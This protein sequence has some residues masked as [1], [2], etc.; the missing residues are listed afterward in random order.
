M[1]DQITTPHRLG[2]VGDGVHP[3]NPTG[4]SGRTYRRVIEAMGVAKPLSS[5]LVYG[6]RLRIGSTITTHPGYAIVFAG[7]PED[8]GPIGKSGREEPHSQQQ[9]E[10]QFF[11]HA[12][13]Y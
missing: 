2:A 1:W 4:T 6:R 12:G 8:V 11:Y 5:Q 3:G 13:L 10:K 9:Y 7:D